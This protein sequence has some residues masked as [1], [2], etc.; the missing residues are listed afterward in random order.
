M[1][2]KHLLI[3]GVASVAL[4]PLAIL[5]G[6]KKPQADTPKALPAPEVTRE[7]SEE[8]RKKIAAEWGRKGAEKSAQVRRAKKAARAEAKN[9]LPA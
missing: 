2:K 9:E 1:Q 8:E 4:L 5:T 3:L 6:K 7:I